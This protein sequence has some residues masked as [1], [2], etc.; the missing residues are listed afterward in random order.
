MWSTTP[1]RKRAE[2]YVHRIG[3]TGRAG[4]S[5]ISIS[6]ACEDDAFLL[7]PIEKLLDMKLPCTM[8]DEELLPKFHHQRVKSAPAAKRKLK[9]KLLKSLSGS[10]AG[11]QRIRNPQRPLVRSL[12]STQ[13]KSRAPAT[14][15]SSATLRRARAPTSLNQ[16]PS[17]SVVKSRLLNQ[18]RKSRRNNRLAP[19]LLLYSRTITGCRPQQ[20]GSRNRFRMGTAAAP[21]QKTKP[22]ITSAARPRAPVPLKLPGQYPPDNQNTAVPVSTPLNFRQQG[23]KK[24]HQRIKP[25]TKV[26]TTTITVAADRPESV[27]PE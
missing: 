1:C 26:A 12:P 17:A 10:N 11:L 13:F 6:F 3:R 5:G 18:A 27:I 15:E 19:T 24:V 4:Q 21:G 25:I 20:A 23:R 22:R 14:A 8:P 2:D 16:E 9:K 7:E